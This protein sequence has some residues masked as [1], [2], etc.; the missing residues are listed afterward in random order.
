MSSFYSK[1]ILKNQQENRTILKQLHGDGDTSPSHDSVIQDIATPIARPTDIVFSNDNF[2]LI[3][4]Q[5][6]H[7]RQKN[8][9]VQ[10]AMFLIKVI[11]LKSLKNPLLVDILTFLKDGFEVILKQLTK[12]FQPAHHRIAYLTLYQTPMVIA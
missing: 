2:K 4:E 6:S 3:V 12:F 7:L 5:K 8:F 9:K 11:P 10:D 1:W